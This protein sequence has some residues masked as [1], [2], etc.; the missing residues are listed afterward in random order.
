MGNK[1]QG[2]SIQ[3]VSLKL[4][5]PK[6]TL[7]FWEKEFEGILV[8]LRTKG[9]QRRYTLGNISVIKKIKELREKEMGLTEIR[10]HLMKNFRRGIDNLNPSK[11]DFLA[12]RVA[13][14]VREEVYRFFDRDAEEMLK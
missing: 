12:N 5:I 3:E 1:Q 8:P 7:R 11:I 13:D 2:F 10:A 14:V 6:H 9:G 4:K